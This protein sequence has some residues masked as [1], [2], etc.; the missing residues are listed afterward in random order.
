[1]FERFV[2]AYRLAFRCPHE[3]RPYFG[4]ISTRFRSNAR[5]PPNKQIHRVVA[6]NA[7]RIQNTEFSRCPGLYSTAWKLSTRAV[8]MSLNSLEKFHQ[9]KYYTYNVTYNNVIRV[10]YFTIGLSHSWFFTMT[11]DNWLLLMREYLKPYSV[12]YLRQPLIDFRNNY[13]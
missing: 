12:T 1:M 7:R 6:Q 5:I 13:G 11:F 2:R 8:I 4:N 10:Y 9:N 3:W